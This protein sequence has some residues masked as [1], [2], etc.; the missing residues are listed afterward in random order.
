L[1]LQGFFVM[2]FSFVMER[3]CKKLIIG[4]F[5]WLN[6]PAKTTI[7]LFK[8]LHMFKTISKIA[9]V[10]ALSTAGYAN[11]A[12]FTISMVADNDFAIFGGTATSINNVLYQNNV[13]WGSQISQL[14]T[15][16]FN[17]APTD[18]TFYVLAMGGG[19]QENIS[20]KVNGVNITGIPVSVSSNIRSFLSGYNLGSVTN[21][22]YNANLSD[23]Q[24]A[25]ANASWASAAPTIN[26]TDIVIKGA[27]FGSGY[28]FADSTAHLYRFDAFS[29]GVNVPEPAGIA[30]F[31]LGLLGLAA[32]RR[33]KAV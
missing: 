22:T 21:G 31:G 1:E 12:P 20:G 30:L 17:L 15:M 2:P 32:V 11:A 18:T 7:K 23:V 16:T 29:V 13:V 25:F 27:G 5:C 8:E 33:R 3:T 6:L 19:G 14:S 9:A 10:I 26:T 24:T 4:V 28:H